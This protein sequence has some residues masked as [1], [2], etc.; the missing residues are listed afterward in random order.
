MDARLGNARL[1]GLLM[2]GRLLEARATADRLIAYLRERD[3]DRELTVTLQNATIVDEC[4]EQQQLEEL[5]RPTT[6]IPVPHR[7]SRILELARAGS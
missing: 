4:L 5:G 2:A 1:Y 3:D 6:A 7:V